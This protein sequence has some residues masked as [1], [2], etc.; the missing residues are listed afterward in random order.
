MLGHT[1]YHKTLRKMIVLFGTIFNDL[2][3]RKFD[4]SG[5]E[6]KRFKVP[7]SYAPKEK[8]LARITDG[9]IRGTDASINLPVMSFEM[10]GMAYDPERKVSNVQKIVAPGTGGTT[11]KM[12]YTP[13]PYIFSF[14]L[15]IYAQNAEDSTQIL[16][17][18]LPYFK[19][20]FNVTIRELDDV[21][22]FKR[23]IPIRLES[24]SYEDTY[25][26]DFES[27]R[28][29][30]YTLD[31]TVEGNIYG[32]I[33]EE[34]IITKTFIDVASVPDFLAETLATTP[35]IVLIDGAITPDGAIPTDSN[36]EE[37]V[38]INEAPFDGTERT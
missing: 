7:V 17:Q 12:M 30:V 20:H 4:A 27:R 23:D 10:T 31:F 29:I 35:P 15:Y 14:S 6:I 24:I 2:N 16:E 9:G 38:T 21:P 34:K 22:E 18:I 36:Y 5:K 33:T 11:K 32:A 13:T 19:P 1:F 26:G 37:T 3:I 28:A 25:E 8:T